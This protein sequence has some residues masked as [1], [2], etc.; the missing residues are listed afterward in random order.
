MMERT[1]VM[2]KP[3]CVSRRLVGEVVS[4]FEAKGLNIVALKLTQLT[5]QT[6]EKL[7]EVHKARPFYGALTAYAQSGPVVVMVVEGLKAVSVV[8][9][10]IGATFGYDAEPGT[11]RGDFANS[12]GHN[13]VHASDSI[14]RA[15]YE[16]SI[17]FRAEEFVTSDRPDL[18]IIY[19][20]DEA[21]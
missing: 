3:D 6:A 5:P 17:F 16:I 12:K 20:K 9:K 18:N 4:R 11:V 10:L 1:F 13:I 21:G 7:Y 14:E 15:Q 8:R 2:L 19:E